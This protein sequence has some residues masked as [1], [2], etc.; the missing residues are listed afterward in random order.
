VIVHFQVKREKGLKLEGVSGLMCL[1]IIAKL[2]SRPEPVEIKN[3]QS[4]M[5]T[6]HRFYGG[7]CFGGYLTSPPP[8][9]RPFDF[10]SS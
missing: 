10:L 5:E 7:Y 4:V 8:G 6:M 9:R 3:Y 2:L 1:S